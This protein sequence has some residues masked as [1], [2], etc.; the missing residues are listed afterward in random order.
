MLYSIENGKYIT[1]VPHE[2]DFKIWSS[3]L[4]PVEITSIQQALNQIFSGSEIETS[5]WIPGEDWTG[6]VWEPIY[7][8]SCRQDVAAAAKCFGL[9]VWQAVI[10]EK[11]VWAFGRYEKD[12]VPIEG[13]TYF[14]LHNPPP[15][16]LE[17]LNLVGT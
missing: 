10:R 15:A 17:A 8:K 7:S 5:S 6:S 9:F 14:R 16:P 12:G 1:N 4:M 11:D 13:L 2:H 3:R